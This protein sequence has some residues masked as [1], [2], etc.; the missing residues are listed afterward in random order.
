MNGIHSGFRIQASGFST[1]VLLGIVIL[2]TQVTGQAQDILFRG[3]P[4]PFGARGSAL[5]GALVSDIHDIEGL[6]NNPASLRALVFPGLSVDHR[7]DWDQSV[8]FESVALRAF[9]TDF[10]SLGIGVRVTDAGGIG[11]RQQL[12]LRQYAAD[13]GYAFDILPNVSFGVLA[14]ARQG[15]ASGQSKSGYSFSFGLLYAPTQIGRA[16]V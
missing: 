3:D 13:V 16:H 4:Q 5:G 11:A 1:L 7:H 10:H 2:S 6:Y 15:M 9:S 8:F 12:D 14:G